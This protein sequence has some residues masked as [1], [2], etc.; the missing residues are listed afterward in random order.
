MGIMSAKGLSLKRGEL[1]CFKPNWNRAHHHSHAQALHEL[2]DQHARTT[3]QNIAEQEA[4]VSLSTPSM[5][6]EQSS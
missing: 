5:S 3:D 6:A 1:G 4:K 2:Q